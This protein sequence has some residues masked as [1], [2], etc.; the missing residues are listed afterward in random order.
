VDNDWAHAV[1]VAGG[2][3]LVAG[4]VDGRPWLARV[5]VG[6]RVLWERS[7]SGSSAATDVTVAP[8]GAIYVVDEGNL[9][10][11][12]ADGDRS[13][14]R[15]LRLGPDEMGSGVATASDGVVYVTARVFAESGDLW[16]R[17]P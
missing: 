16:R 13:W 8:R 15:R 3:V 10:R 2:R 9:L 4:Q 12:T 11:F 7:W 14:S 1:D 5:W 6:G 17:L